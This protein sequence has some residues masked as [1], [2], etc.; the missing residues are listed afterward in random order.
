M[1]V[2]LHL[3]KSEQ[4]TKP[5]D[6]LSRSV[7]FLHIFNIGLGLYFYCIFGKSQTLPYNQYPRRRLKPNE[8]C[9]SGL[10]DIHNPCGKGLPQSN[11]RIDVAEIFELW[12]SDDQRSHKFKSFEVTF[13]TLFRHASQGGEQSWNPRSQETRSPRGEEPRTWGHPET[14]NKLLGIVITLIIVGWSTGLSL[15]SAIF[16]MLATEYWNTAP[17]R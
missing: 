9:G 8:H 5:T 7:A 12:F 13:Y 11:P 4:L 1:D 10:C 16:S 14:E 6:N 2:I 15:Q 17:S 3:F